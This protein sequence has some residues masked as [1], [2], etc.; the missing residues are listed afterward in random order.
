MGKTLKRQFSL[1]RVFEQRHKLYVLLLQITWPC[2]WENKFVQI[3]HGD[4]IS[5]KTDG[6][7]SCTSIFLSFWTFLFICCQLPSKEQMQQQLFVIV[8]CPLGHMW[9]GITICR[10]NRKANP[11]RYFF[12]FLYRNRQGTSYVVYFAKTFPSLR[13]C[14]KSE[15]ASPLIQV[16]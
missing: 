7:K 12:F 14:F 2:R 4:K 6:V 5:L 16:F 9:F 3:S 8:D 10:K 15:Q 1:E 13:L 11:S